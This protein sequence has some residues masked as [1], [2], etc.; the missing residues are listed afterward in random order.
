MDQET[1]A[2]L[3]KMEEDNGGPIEYKTYC[4]LLGFSNGTSLDLGG[5]LY[6]VNAKLVFEDFEKQPGI[7]DMVSRAKKT[8]DKYKTYRLFD[9]IVGTKKITTSNAKRVLAGKTDGA[10]IPPITGFDKLFSQTILELSFKEGPNWYIELLEDKEF[11]TYIE[12]HRS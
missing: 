11:I 12:E 4:R 8:Y 5:L 2:L 7:L 1:E 9:D 10:N 6:V 3:K